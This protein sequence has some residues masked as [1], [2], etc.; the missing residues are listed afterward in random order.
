MHGT[1]NNVISLQ[2]RFG[3]P[4]DTHGG[5]KILLGLGLDLGIGLEILLGL[6][7]D[8]GLARA[9]LGLDLGLGQKLGEATSLRVG[10]EIF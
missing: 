4:G 7:L 8:L 3:T 10:P 6:G 2:T 1:P 9:D 5:L